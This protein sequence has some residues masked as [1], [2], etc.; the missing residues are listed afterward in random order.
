MPT[1]DISSVLDVHLG[2]EC[3]PVG[4]LAIQHRP[5]R[6]VILR[7]MQ[8]SHEGLVGINLVSDVNLK[9]ASIGLRTHDCVSAQLTSSEI[10]TD[11]THNRKRRK[12]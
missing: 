7:T 10:A 4:N 5:M 6:D 2:S 3:P 8:A 9:D 12:G 1:Q 11:E